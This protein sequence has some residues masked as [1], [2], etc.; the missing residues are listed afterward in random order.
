MK[1]VQ[2]IDAAENCTFSV[3]QLTDD[4]FSAVFPGNG[5][6][7]EFIED[8]IE[9][10]GE[11]AAGTVLAPMWDRPIR[12]ADVHGIDGTLFYE[13]DKKRKYFPMSKRERDWDPR[14]LNAAQRRLYGT[15]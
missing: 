3:F 13:F 10:L 7:I 4:E 5:Q 6:D 1:N 8:L 9:R 14:S 15:S 2:V 11:K 12:K